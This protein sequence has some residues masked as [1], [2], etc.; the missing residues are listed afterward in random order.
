MLPIFTASKGTARCQFDCSG[1]TWYVYDKTGVENIHKKAY[2]LRTTWSNEGASIVNNRGQWRRGDILVFSGHWAIYM[3]RNEK[4]ED[5]MYNALSPTHGIK[6]MTVDSY[7]NS[8]GEAEEPRCA[9]HAPVMGTMV[10][11]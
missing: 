3:G 10:V 1:L 4:G 11:K 6:A 2:G 7:R 8:K 5:M 9:W